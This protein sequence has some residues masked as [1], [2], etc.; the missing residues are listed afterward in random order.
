MIQA[1]AH[2]QPQA[3]ALSVFDISD[4]LI[5][6][7]GSNLAGIHGAGAARVARL[8]HG[9]IM[10][11]GEGLQGMSYA[12]PTKDHKIMTLPLSVVKFHV[13]TFKTFA[14]NN[15][16]LLFQVT[17][18]GCGLAGLRDLDVAPMFRGSPNNCYFD[19]YWSSILGTD[20]KIWGTY[21]G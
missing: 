16:N 2:A 3:H 5:F 11:Q 13:E 21:N 12:L 15:P 9:A 10:G 6:V 19:G 18:V 7:F 14:E 1:H 8:H 4:P 17:R 20:Y